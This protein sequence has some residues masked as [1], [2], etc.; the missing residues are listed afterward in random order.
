MVLEQDGDHS[1]ALSR[2]VGMRAA[3]L[4]YCRIRRYNKHSAGLG[5]V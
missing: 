2:H 1:R 5:E 3:V 4:P